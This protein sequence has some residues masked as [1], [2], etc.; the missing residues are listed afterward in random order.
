MS[1]HNFPLRLSLVALLGG[2]LLAGCPATTAQA[3]TTP[4]T[5]TVSFKQKDMWTVLNYIVQK[6]GYQLEGGDAVRQA[7]IAV[8]VDFDETTPAAALALLFENKPF[9]YTLDGKHLRVVRNAVT[10]TP[11]AAKTTGQ[12]TSGTTTAQQTVAEGLRGIVRDGAGHPV[13]SANVQL[14]G[15]KFVAMTQEDGTFVLPTTAKSG[16]LLVSSIG[17][18]SSTVK[19]TNG[20][21]PRVTLRETSLQLGEATVVAY[22]ERNSRELVGAVSSIKAENSRMLQR[23]ASKTSCKVSSLAWL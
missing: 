3:Q 15:T 21:V 19:F 23:P 13:M 5:I 4:T 7:G 11:T 12:A 14:K 10:V 22:G 8:T 17:Y 20:V 2:V 9:L 16:E 1:Q 18:Q 6:G